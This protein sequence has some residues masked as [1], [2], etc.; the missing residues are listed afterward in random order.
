[1][2]KQLTDSQMSALKPYED[3]LRTMHFSGWARNITSGTFKAMKAIFDSITGKDNHVNPNC[4]VCVSDMVKR[5][6]DWY[7]AT[8]D[9]ETKRLEIEFRER[10]ARR[11]ARAAEMRIEA[12][13][14]IKKQAEK[15]LADAN[16]RLAHAERMREEAA[17]EL[18]IA[19]TA[20]AAA[21]SNAMYEKNIAAAERIEA[22]AVE[23]EQMRA[24]ELAAGATCEA[25]DST[26]SPAPGTDTGKPV[27]AAKKPENKAKPAR[28]PRNM[29]PKTN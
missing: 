2:I 1:M 11:D 14:T 23:A 27:K 28:L 10:A 20:R 7:Y 24:P 16:E 12:A 9:A 15:A 5:L 19:R 13:E 3:T 21:E 25:Q 6:G 4:N 18:E 17:R 8:K 26:S 22:E 29:K